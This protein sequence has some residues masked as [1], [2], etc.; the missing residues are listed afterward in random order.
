[1]IICTYIYIYIYYCY[2]CTPMFAAVS[3]VWKG[4]KTILHHSTVNHC[5]SDPPDFEVPQGPRAPGSLR[6]GC[7]TVLARCQQ[8]V[9]QV[10][11]QCGH[12]HQCLYCLSSVHLILCTAAQHK[13][14]VF[15]FLFQSSPILHRL[16]CFVSGPNIMARPMPSMTRFTA[17]WSSRTSQSLP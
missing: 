2:M 1:M 8:A 10:V 11:D 4:R 15:W 9:A 17:S 3:V 16:C 13:T 6:K 14:W 7:P 12:N 5:S